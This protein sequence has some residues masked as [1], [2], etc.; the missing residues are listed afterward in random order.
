MTRLGLAL[1]L[2][3]VASCAHAPQRSPFPAQVFLQAP[4]F[5]GDV[6]YDL[7]ILHPDSPALV[8]SHPA[9]DLLAAGIGG[10]ARCGP[11]LGLP[12]L[13]SEHGHRGLA[14]LPLRPLR[15]APDRDSAFAVPELHGAVDL[16]AVLPAG[17]GS[18]ARL[19]FNLGI[20]DVHHRIWHLRQDGNRHG[21]SVDAPAPLVGWNT[22]PAMPSRFIAKGIFRP[23]AAYTN[24]YYT[25][26]LVDDLGVK[27]TSCQRGAGTPR[28]A[29]SRDPLRRLPL[30]LRGF[31]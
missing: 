31:L 29:P 19:P 22:L 12:K 15:F 27:D 7:A 11:V 30:R 1:L 17:S 18:S 23:S 10:S 20:Q 25:R 21:A 28:A 9:A 5:P 26:S 2:A 3:L 6:V 16:V 13:R 14:V 24:R 8:P 4:A